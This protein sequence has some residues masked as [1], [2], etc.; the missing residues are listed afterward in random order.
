MERDRRVEGAEA[1]RYAEG[2]GGRLGANRNN[3]VLQRGD[4]EGVLPAQLLGFGEF[5]LAI[6]AKAVDHL[7]ISYNFV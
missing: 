3:G 7:H 1:L 6:P 4:P 5:D 2:H